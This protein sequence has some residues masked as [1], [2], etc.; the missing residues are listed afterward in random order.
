MNCPG[1]CFGRGSPVRIQAQPLKAGEIAEQTEMD[2]NEVS[3][4]IKKLVS[5]GKVHSPRYCYYQAK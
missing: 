1:T 2:K 3:K 5:E 4:M